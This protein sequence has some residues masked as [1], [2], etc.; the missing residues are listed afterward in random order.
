MVFVIIFIFILFI[1]AIVTDGYRSNKRHRGTDSSAIFPFAGSD[2]DDR[3]HS[4][5]GFFDWGGGG[6]SGGSD[7]G[8]GGGGGGD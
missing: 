1:A 5:S 6:D 7:G 8:G 3:H 4:D 2:S